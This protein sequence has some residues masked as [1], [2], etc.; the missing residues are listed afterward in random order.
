MFAVILI[1][2]I[3]ITVVIFLLLIFYR[4]LNGLYEANIINCNKKSTQDLGLVRI[5]RTICKA[6]VSSPKWK[7][8]GTKKEINST[9][10]F[11]FRSFSLF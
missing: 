9:H 11:D 2:F 10:T 7:S 4:S 8:Y 1:S 6:A 3:I 5:A